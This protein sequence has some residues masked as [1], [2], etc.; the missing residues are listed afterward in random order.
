MGTPRVSLVQEFTSTAFQPFKAPC[1]PH[2]AGSIHLPS[3]I[4]AERKREGRGLAIWGDSLGWTYQHGR[5]LGKPIRKMVYWVNSTS[6]SSFTGDPTKM[7]IYLGYN[8]D[9]IVWVFYP[10]LG[11]LQ[12]L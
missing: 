2:K 9:T 7:L 6:N 8:W 4:P 3:S 1:V 12:K 10:W 5:P 11:K